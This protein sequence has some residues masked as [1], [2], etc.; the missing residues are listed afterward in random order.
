MILQPAIESTN[1]LIMRLHEALASSQRLA[2]LSRSLIARTEK[3]RED[4]YKAI[5]Q[6]HAIIN[7]AKTS[8]LLLARGVETRHRADECRARNERG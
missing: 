2:F 5:E 3:V 4:S 7:K 1:D 6:S 8:D